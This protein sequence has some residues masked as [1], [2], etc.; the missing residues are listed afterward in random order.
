MNIFLVTYNSLSKEEIPKI[1]DGINKYENVSVSPFVW[2]IET[3]SWLTTVTIR[4]E[5]TKYITDNDS[6]FI[7][8]LKDASW[9]IPNSEISGELNQ[10]FDRFYNNLNN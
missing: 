3:D 8:Q 9:F 1:Q 5:L 2:L 7:A 4:E 10:K 6:I